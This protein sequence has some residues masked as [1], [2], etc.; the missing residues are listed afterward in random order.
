MPKTHKEK[1]LHAIKSGKELTL[2][3]AENV[4]GVPSGSVSQRIAELRQ[5][6]ATIYT[7]QKRMKGGPNKGKKVTAYRLST[8]QQY[9]GSDEFEL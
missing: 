5:A 8:P 1:I 4:L 6:G 3:F 9:N 7:N 2:T